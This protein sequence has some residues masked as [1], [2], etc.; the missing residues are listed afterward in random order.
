[1]AL[2][3]SFTIKKF[4]VIINKVRV[5]NFERGRI[6]QELL[7]KQ[8]QIQLSNI[9]VAIDVEQLFLIYDLEG[10][11]ITSFLFALYLLPYF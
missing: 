8:E 3:T 7:Q 2:F 10:L 9:F 11:D 1:M 6:V 5:R 4:C